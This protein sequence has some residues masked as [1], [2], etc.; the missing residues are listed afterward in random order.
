M[1]FQGRQM[2]WSGWVN[3][4]VSDASKDWMVNRISALDFQIQ[5][6]PHANVEMLEVRRTF[7][8]PQPV[9][10]LPA[11]TLREHLAGKSPSAVALFR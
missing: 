11:Y 8:K 1:Q 3:E 5:Y 6:G 4:S 10:F 2:K 7:C 9:A